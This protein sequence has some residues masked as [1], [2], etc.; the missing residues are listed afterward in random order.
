ME[1]KILL[2]GIWKLYYRDQ[3]IKADAIL[4]SDSIQ[5]QVPGN[6]ELDL[7]R[8]GLLPEDLYKGMNTRISEKFERYEWWYELEFMAQKALDNEKVFLRFDGVDCIA[9][10]FLNDIRIGQ[11]DNAFI[12]HEFD[13]SSCIAEGRNVLRVHISSALLYQ[14]DQEY[15]QYQFYGWHLEGGTYL[16]KPAHCFGWDIFPR[17]ISAGI[18][19]SVSLI[20]CDEY[21]FEE[22]SYIVNFDAEMNPNLDFCYSIKAPYD[23]LLDGSLKVEITGTCGEDSS[24]LAVDSPKQRK[25]GRIKSKITNPRLWW[26]LGYGKANVYDTI[27]TLYRNGKIVAQKKL[28]VGLRKLELKRTESMSDPDPKFQFEI[29]GV[30]VM[31]RGSNWVPMDAYHS[32]DILRYEKAMELVSDIGCNMLRIWGGGVYEQE[33]FYDYCDRHGIMIWQDFMMACQLCPMD[34]KML[35]N[36][37]NEFTQVINTL[38]HHP[39]IVLWAGDN[40]I[41]ESLAG[42]GITPSFNTIT[43][44]LLPRLVMEH[45]AFRPYLPSSPYISDENFRKLKNGKDDLVERHLWGARDYYKADFYSKSKACFVSETG[46]HG[47]PSLE[48]L[49][50]IVDEDHIWPIFNEQWTLHSSDQKNNDSRVKLMAD[51]IKQLFAFEPNNI[52][53]F[54]L[55]SQ[56]SQAEAKKYFIERIRIKRPHTGGILWWNL[57]DGWPQMSDAVVDYFYNKKLAY[58][59]IKRSQAPFALMMDEMHDWNYTLFAAN[60]TLEQISGSYEVR[61]IESDEIIASGDFSILPNCSKPL[62]K[63]RMIYSD[64]KML[65]IKWTIDK[66]SYYNHYLAGMPAFSF[67]KYKL[68]LNKLN[69]I[70]I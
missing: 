36:L 5:A 8:A 27:A 21:D 4:P 65:L 28:I 43:R 29:N 59:Y 12:Y 44:Q 64:Q 35:K 22:L 62:Q 23:A 19:K 55:A 48:S 46:Y 50:K 13:V 9:E 67:E 69:S 68:W 15:S 24:F 11:S 17:A 7:S 47:C 32:Q 16:R 58:S 20:Y 30:D 49:K 45:D 34:D 2:D 18:W 31:C 14:L 66:K 60:D 63:L 10:Y 70:I 37:K 51:Q 33:Y 38:R 6:V 26:P 3:T 53:D 52:E 57:L 61:D 54:I 39:S 42:G 56:I 1:R 25:L 40:E 41:D